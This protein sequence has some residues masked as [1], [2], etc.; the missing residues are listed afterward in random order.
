M[1]N[2]LEDMIQFERYSGISIIPN[3]F[4]AI[5]VDGR[6][7]HTEV[8]KMKMER[9]FDRKLRTAIN[10]SIKNVMKDFGCLFAYTESDEVTFLFPK[11]SRIFDRRLE[12]LV[13]LVASKMS[14]EFLQCI[15]FFKKN[16]PKR[17]QVFLGDTFLHLERKP[18]FS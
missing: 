8:K 13:S 14:V 4:F 9:P 11:E 10:K 7:F 1:E 18:I 17:E 12:K 6:S 2:K 16:T 3:S 5:R 15:I